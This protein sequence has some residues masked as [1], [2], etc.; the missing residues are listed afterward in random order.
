VLL[1]NNTTKKYDVR[2]LTEQ[3]KSRWKIFLLLF[4]VSYLLAFIILTLVADDQAQRQENRLTVSLEALTL[5]QAGQV[6]ATLQTITDDLLFFAQLPMVK[7]YSDHDNDGDQQA[8]EQTFLQAAKQKKYIAQIRIIDAKGQETIRVDSTSTGPVI[9]D[10]SR[11]QDKSSRYYFTETMSLSENGLYISPLDLNME[12]GKIEEPWN[13]VLRIATPL[14]NARGVTSGIMVINIYGRILL[15]PFHPTDQTQHNSYL[16][17]KSGY[18]LAGAEPKKLWS[19]MFDGTHR[20]G[21]EHPDAWAKI[22]TRTKGHFVGKNNLFTFQSITLGHLLGAN[23]EEIK[24]AQDTGIWKIVNMQSL[25]SQGFWNDTQQA[26]ALAGIGF[27]LALV[28]WGWS[29][30]LTE[31]R[32][33]K[34]AGAVLREMITHADVS[35]AVQNIDRSYSFIN[36]TF[37]RFIGKPTADI[38]GQKTEDIFQADYAKKENDKFQQVLTCEAPIRSESTLTTQDGELVLLSTHFPLI[39]EKGTVYA[40]ACI[41]SDISELKK[42][43]NDLNQAV[44]TTELANQAKSSFL[45]SMSHELRTPLNAIIGYSEMLIEDIE[46]EADTDMGP[47][48]KRIFKAGKHLL[49]LVNDILDISKIEAGKMMLDVSDFNFDALILEVVETAGGLAHKNNNKL[50]VEYPDAQ[51]GVITTD[52]LKVRQV[53]LNLLSNASKFCKNGTIKL[54][55]DKVHDQGEDKLMVKVSD[56]GIGIPPESLATL[57]DEF[58]QVNSSINRTYGGTG[59]GLAISKK[60]VELM[61][62]SIEVTSEINQGTCFTVIL[63]TS[64]E[65]DPRETVHLPLS[66]QSQKEKEQCILVID[67]DMS[68]R[69]LLTRYLTREGFLVTTASDAVEG[70]KLAKKLRPDAIILDV[71][72]PELSG[73]EVMSALKEDAQTKDIPVVMCTIVDDKQ[74]GLSLGAVDY[75]TKPIEREQLIRSLRRYLNMPEKSYI[76]I[77]DDDEDACELAVRYSQEYGADTVIAGNGLEALDRINEFGTPDLILLDLMMPEMDGFE[78]LHEFKSHKTNMEV[79]VIVITAKDFSQEEKTYLSQQ[80]QLIIEKGAENLP[81]VLRSLLQQVF[82][83]MKF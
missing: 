69:D 43:Q 83:V 64:L 53:I 57:F 82:S 68:S 72:L 62:G 18:W 3:G 56:T 15:E 50:L 81:Q 13:P 52:S 41:S 78:F 77:V 65:K 31:R 44:E 17:N 70:M 16:L 6:Q 36:Q 34:Q 23:T 24:I 55:I 74:R 22:A 63:P 80:T 59:L 45:A 39:D 42:M 30:Y 67:D 9:Y 26:F 37:S 5:T 58:V 51:A 66:L 40:I 27:I 76:L 47:D 35:V 7:R 46:N 2:Q 4:P 71:I 25:E 14:V 8:I 79:P 12:R 21:L 48:I 33:A 1:K 54:E 49:A 28:C 60:F 10:Q 20:F 19:F 73:W 61:G 11:L 32:I 29:G 75:L 38:L